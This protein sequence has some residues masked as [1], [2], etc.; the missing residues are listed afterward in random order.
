MESGFS[1]VV[2]LCVCIC[3]VFVSFNCHMYIYVSCFSIKKKNKLPHVCL[4][5]LKI[6]IALTEYV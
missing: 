1:S 3:T 2:A 4:L 6:Y 5:L